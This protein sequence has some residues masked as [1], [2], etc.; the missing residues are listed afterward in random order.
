MRK[1]PQ[2]IFLVGCFY[3]C[4]LRLEKQFLSLP[5]N[6]NTM[7]RKSMRGSS[8]SSIFR[9]YI[10]SWLSDRL[11]ILLCYFFKCDKSIPNLPPC[12][13]DQELSQNRTINFGNFNGFLKVLTI[14]LYQNAHF[15]YVLIS[16]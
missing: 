8:A 10:N 5:S 11:N 12:P 14:F 7:N 16:T 13:F 1:S 2:A 3:F 9:Y 4:R 15:S 6:P